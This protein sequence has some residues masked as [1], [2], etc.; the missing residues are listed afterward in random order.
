MCPHTALQGEAQHAGHFGDEPVAGRQTAR[1]GRLG[2]GRPTRRQFA[3]LRGARR[4]HHDVGSRPLQVR[5]ARPS[6]R[7]GG[8]R[9]GLLRVASSH[10]RFGQIR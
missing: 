1:D 5:H 8:I 6:G 3:A 4:G 10:S 9:L 7:R 2:R